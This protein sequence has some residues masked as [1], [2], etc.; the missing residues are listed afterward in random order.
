MPVREFKCSSYRAVLGPR[1]GFSYHQTTNIE[2]YGRIT[3]VG[4]D[5]NGEAGTLTIHFLSETS[6]VPEPPALTNDDATKGFCCLP[7]S[8]WAAVMDLVRNE[9]PIALELNSDRPEW[10]SLTAAREDVGA[11]DR[12]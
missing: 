3:V 10:N 7:M 11:G 2:A 1:I 8:A 6:P 9:G 5:A 4:G 12:G